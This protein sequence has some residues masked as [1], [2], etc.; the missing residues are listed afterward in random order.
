MILINEIKTE[1][2]ILRPTTIDDVEF[3]LQQL[4]MPKWHEFI[5][6]RKVKTLAQAKKYITTKLRP[7]IDKLGYGTFTVIRKSDGV[8]LGTC[9]LYDREGIEGIDIGFAFLTQYEKNGYA[10]ESSNKLKQVALNKFN[11]K[12][13]NAIT[14][15]K[16]IS[17]QKLLEKLG[18]KYIK[19]IQLADEGE[20]VMLYQYKT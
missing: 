3:I 1:R 12:H 2:L 11:L 19:M 15:V 7:Q 20:Q 17:S 5:G 16:N 9:G 13:I 10:Y 18:L 14:T 4:N 8:K 6:D